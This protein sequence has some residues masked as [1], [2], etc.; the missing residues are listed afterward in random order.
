MRKKYES[1]GVR[2]VNMVQTMRKKYTEQDVVDKMKKFGSTMEVVHDVDNK[3]GPGY[4]ARGFPTMVVVGKSGN[5][6]AVNVGNI[7]VGVF[8]YISLGQLPIELL[9]DLSYPSLTVQTIYPDAAPVSVERFVT[10]PIE[11]TVGVIPGVREMRSTSSAAASLCR[12]AV[13]ACISKRL[14]G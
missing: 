9:P 8:G 6:E 5:V 7:A 3:V 11:E 14:Q 12:E 4:G 1:K 10:R 13:L 2:F